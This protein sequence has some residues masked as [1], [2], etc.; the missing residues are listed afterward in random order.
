MTLIQE[1]DARISVVA[2]H[3]SDCFT[4]K[5]KK[6]A[7]ARPVSHH[8]AKLLI[9]CALCSDTLFIHALIGLRKGMY[10]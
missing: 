1:E 2:K 8:R 9:Y 4:Q 10:K 7:F 5:L 6:T 3:L